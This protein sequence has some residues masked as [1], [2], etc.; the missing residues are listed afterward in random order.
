[1]HILD[2]DNVNWDT[3]FSSLND[4]A[5]MPSSVTR[6]NPEGLR[7]YLEHNGIETTA[8]GQ[9]HLAGIPY[10]NGGGFNG[11]YTSNHGSTYVQYHPG[12]GHH[13]KGA[14]YK[15]SS[16]NVFAYSGKLTG[17]QRFRMDGTVIQYE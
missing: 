3:A 13:G 6:M 1:M 15:V 5:E 17:T 14:Y 4:I 9:G 11:H 7:W 2:Y 10:E 8:L 16:G 12:E